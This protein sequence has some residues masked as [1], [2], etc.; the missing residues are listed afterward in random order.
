MADHVL[1][2]RDVGFL[3]LRLLAK[4]I[5]ENAELA[6]GQGNQERLEHDN[7]LSQASIQVVVVRVQLSP[8]FLGIQ[9]VPSG[10]VIGG[11][12]EILAKILDHLLQRAYLMKEL[13]PMGEQHE[14]EEATHASRS[15]ALLSLKIGGIERGSVGTGSVML[16]VV[17]QSM[18]QACER[19]GQQLA[20]ARSY[21]YGLKGFAGVSQMP[22]FDS[23]I[24]RHAQHEVAGFKFADIF[25]ENLVLFFWKPRAPIV[26]DR[27]AAG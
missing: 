23:L 17:G 16:G 26:F 18:K 24:E 9:I 25:V 22:Q 7:G 21:A 8:H 14:V 27:L 13:E 20:E 19:L 3:R 2:G 15:L 11:M 10:E 5:L 12:A 1:A 6:L 4:G